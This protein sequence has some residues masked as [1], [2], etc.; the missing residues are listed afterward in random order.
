MKAVTKFLIC[1]HCVKY[2]RIRV[3]VAHIFPYGKRRFRENP[4]S[5]LFYPVFFLQS[6]L[7]WYSKYK[8]PLI[9]ISRS[10]IVSSFYV[11]QFHIAI[12]L[13]HFHILLSNDN[14]VLLSGFVFRRLFTNHLKKC[15]VPFFSFSEIVLK[16][17]KQ[18]CGVVL[19]A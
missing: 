17:D 10:F 9:W 4:Y 14:W 7:I 5:C 19:L 13:F 2:T 3:S 6:W 18:A 11:I 16:F 1:L 15:S 8:L 12:S